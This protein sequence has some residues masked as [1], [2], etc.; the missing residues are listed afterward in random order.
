MKPLCLSRRRAL[1][2][3]ASLCLPAIG[4]QS[5]QPALPGSSVYQLRP[6]LTDQNG[7]AFDI[8][9]LRGQPALVSMFYGS[10]DMVCPMIFQTIAQTV[11]T[12]P[13][14][15]RV[16]VRVLMVSF[17]PQR[18][19][20]AVLKQLAQTHQCDAQWTLARTDEDQARLLAA[21]LGVQYRRLPSGEFN[22]SSTV[23]LLDAQGRIVAR[24]GLLGRVDPLLLR[25]LQAQLQPRS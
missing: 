3:S 10:C 20:V 19:S 22:H 7:Q 24:S 18:D 11:Q 23:L 6:P 5:A 12:L 9:S 17:D 16:R 13:A 14:R 15:D 2:L 8:A 25:A 4:V 1:L 21:V